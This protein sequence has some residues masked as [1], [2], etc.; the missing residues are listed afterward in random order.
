[1]GIET[2]GF[3]EL[4]EMLN[5]LMRSA[6]W[7][8]A[9]KALDAGAEVILD[10]MKQKAT[11]DPQRR[12]G[13]LHDSLARSGAKLYGKRKY[14]TIGVHR[15]DW[16]KRAHK[17]GS[18]ENYYY[19]AYVEFGHGGPAPAPPHPYIRVSFDEM[20]PEALEAMKDVLR[21]ELKFK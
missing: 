2:S 14:I 17:P 5:E 18:G 12:T 16:E 19:P 13:D 6:N 11:I 10:K 9:K 7:R 4:G 1:M 20:H 15:K 3:D 21:Q 8:V